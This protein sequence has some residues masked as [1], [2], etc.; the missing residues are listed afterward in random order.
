MIQNSNLLSSIR[1]I[2]LP[3][4]VLIKPAN[5]AAVASFLLA[6]KNNTLLAFIE[7]SSIKF[8]LSSSD[9][10]LSIGPFNVPSSS[11]VM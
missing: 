11:K 10:N 3:K 2:F 5:L 6:I 4:Y 8:F 7:V 9:K 1:P